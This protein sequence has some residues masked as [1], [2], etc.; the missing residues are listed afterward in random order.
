MSYN[1][2]SKVVGK[3]GSLAPF[4]IP[5]GNQESLSGSGILALDCLHTKLYT[6]DSDGDFSLSRG[7][8]TGQLKRITFVYKGL[9]GSKAV[10]NIPDFG[11]TDTEIVFH[12]EGDTAE[13]MWDGGL[14]K[15]LYTLNVTDPRQQTPIVQ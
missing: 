12:N 6:V 2:T 11:G 15:V 8:Q 14:W 3:S 5:S 13:L 9:D 7:L 1:V 4:I 10:C